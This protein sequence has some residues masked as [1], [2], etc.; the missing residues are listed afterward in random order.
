MG[1][2]HHG[3]S[4]SHRKHR[5]SSDK[6]RQSSRSSRGREPVA[7]PH[8]A[9]NGKPVEAKLVQPPPSAR[10]EWAA[11]SAYD[12]RGR[13]RRG[14]GFSSLGST[15]K[16]IGLAVVALGCMGAGWYGIHMAF[17]S[18]D[19]SAKTKP[20]SQAVAQV[21]TGKAT[22]PK[23][24]TPK[25]TEPAKVEPKAEPKVE[26]KAEPKVEPKT[27]PKTEPKPPE[28][29]I[30]PSV[31]VV[32]FKDV[33][34][35][36]QVKCNDC[37]TGAKAKGKFDGNSI[38][39]MLKPTADSMK[40]GLVPGDPEKSQMWLSIKDK[41]MPPKDKPQLTPEEKEKILNWIKGGAREVAVAGGNPPAAGGGEVLAYEKHILPL[42]TRK[43]AK[44]HDGIE[45]KS[46]MDV[47]TLA[48]LKKGGNGGAGVTPG[49][50]K[51]SQLWA[52]LD[53]NTMPPED[54]GVPL[55]EKEKDLV[56]RW[57]TAGAKDNKEA[58]LTKDDAAALMREFLLAKK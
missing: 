16:G 41:E 14:S 7:R 17:N 56:K 46:G 36:L 52:V 51:K 55:T 28:P 18:K 31:P 13:R 44:C 40:P 2:D 32:L 43:C 20:T 26:P 22:T 48:S 53:T 45:K 38:A 8:A 47:T 19:T 3:S 37:H 12:S 35:I 57:I 30:D 58:M 42:L 34:P 27:E 10:S 6:H 25:A 39:A 54:M 11:A 33:L 15:L 24:D 29:K 9:P 50:L 1:K 49:D 21:D 4:G 23:T 5:S